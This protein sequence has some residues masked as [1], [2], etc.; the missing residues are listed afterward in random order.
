MVTQRAGSAARRGA[1]V[2]ALAVLMALSSL[3]SAPLPGAPSAAQAGPSHDAVLDWNRH[4]MDA[5]VNAPTA[6]TPGAGQPPPVS[7]QHLAMVQAAVYD[8]VNAIDR[9]HRPYLTGLPQVPRSAST[10]AAVA[11]AAHDVLVGVRLVP[12]LP[13]AVVDRL[14]LLRDQSIAAATTQDG[15]SAVEA[16][17]AAGRAAAAAMLAARAADGR[18]GPFRFTEGLGLGQWR[19]TSGVTDPN[20]WVARVVP[21]TLTSTSQFRTRGPLPLTSRAYAREYQ[22]VKDLGGDGV[23]TP[24]RRTPEQTAVAL[25]YSGNP[26]EMFHRAFREMPA[27][28]RLGLVG[29]ARLFAMLDVA[30]AD[31]FIN[32]WDDKAHWSFWRPVTAIR[33]GDGDGNPRTAGDPTWTSL[34][35]S[36]PYPDHPSGYNCVTAALMHTAEAV[37]GKKKVR[38]SVTSFV[39]SPPNPITREYRRFRDV[40][41]DTIDARVYLGIHFRTPDVQA[42]QLGADVARWVAKR[43][44]Q[45]VRR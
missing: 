4:A 13:A 40:V 34:V 15:A 10:A 16:G 23:T 12:A 25:F 42:A 19:A 43:H 41:A 32:C 1:Q 35:A 38:F 14:H 31:A 37:L 45:P 18:Y 33:A 11:T 29:Q 36:P 28:H 8:A 2:V 30:A 3:A 21:F 20:A 5:L 17:V 6:A 39:G 9:G 24:T 44:F 27:V 22:E 7:M 26:V